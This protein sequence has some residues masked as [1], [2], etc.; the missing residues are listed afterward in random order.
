M[1]L[2][3][4]DKD[5]K[6]F[7]A[8][9]LRDILVQLPNAA[10]TLEWSVLELDALPAAGCEL[11]VSSVSETVAASQR[12]VTLKWSELESLANSVLQIIDGK[13]AAYRP[14]S[15][16][17]VKGANVYEDSEYVIEAVD[18]TYWRVFSRDDAA[19]GRL[20]KHFKEIRTL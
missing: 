3:I 14:G 11:R 5:E 9:D 6:G 15:D 4:Y 8:F 18:S 10:W 1:L 2:E 13:F 19:L 20:R 17:P 16:L 12:G 7:L